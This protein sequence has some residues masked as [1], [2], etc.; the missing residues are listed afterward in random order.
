[1]EWLTGRSTKEKRSAVMNVLKVM[2]VDG[3]IE[4]PEMNF[5]M[6]VAKRVGLSEKEMKSI[7]Q[8]P[9]KVKFVV[10]KEPS[11]RLAQLMDA[12]FM[13]IADGKIDKRE[14]DACMSLATR[15]EFKPSIVPNLVAHI[16]HAVKEGR[17]R[18]QARR[19]LSKFV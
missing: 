17:N 13:M 3:K 16:V 14:M 4:P 12:V 19:D 5:L 18:D 8:K 7:L 6:A 10:P 2:S 11:E 9:D 1:M 15:L